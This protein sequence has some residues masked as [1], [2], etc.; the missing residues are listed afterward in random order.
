MKMATSFIIDQMVDV[1]SSL[2][3]IIMEALLKRFKRKLWLCCDRMISNRWSGYV[4][5]SYERSSF[6]LNTSDHFYIRHLSLDN[7]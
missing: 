3:G 1:S 5:F 7:Y 4:V 2:C 6:G